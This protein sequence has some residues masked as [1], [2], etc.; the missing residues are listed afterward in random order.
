MGS[1]ITKT[2]IYK[3]MQEDVKI[4]R[5]ASAILKGVIETVEAVQKQVQASMTAL[6]K[7]SSAVIAKVGDV[8]KKV[9]DVK[10]VQ[11]KIESDV[12]KLNR[13]AKNALA[14]KGKEMLNG[15]ENEAKGFLGGFF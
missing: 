8:I 12:G 6:D 2:E 1:A 15:A 14:G 11:T 7:E 5:E 10:G 4:I 9:E 3:E 13:A